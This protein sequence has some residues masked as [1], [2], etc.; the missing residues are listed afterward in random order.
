MEIINYLLM[1]RNPRTYIDRLRFCLD[2]K[3]SKKIET[4]FYLGA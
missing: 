4:I 3:R 1:L 2:P